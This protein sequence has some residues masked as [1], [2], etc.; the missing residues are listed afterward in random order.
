MN[1]RDSAWTRLKA[2]RWASTLGVLVT[3]AVGIL[4]GTLISFSV[5]GQ[6]KTVNSSDATPITIPPAKVVQ[7]DFSRIAKQIEPAV[8]NI[9]T[10]G[11]IKHPSMRG[12]PSPGEPPDNGGGDEDN[13]F[14][15]FFDRFFGGQGGG[16]SAIP[17]RSL[18][19]GVIV[20]PKGY[21]ITN[22]H[23]VEG[24]DRVRVV[25]TS[26]P[27]GSLGHDAKVIGTD[28][29]TDLA[30]VKINV[31]KPLPVAH[32]GNSD[33]LVVGDWVLAVGSP[34]G[35]NA[36]VTAGIV[37]Y[38][39]RNIVPA[40]QFQSFIQTDAAINPGNSG[41]PMVNM[42]GQVVGI[43]TAIMTGGQGYEGVG[44]ALPSN[45][46]AQVYNA[47]ISPDHKVVRGSIGVEFQAVQNPAVLR[48]YGNGENGVVISNIAS[49][50]P[51]DQA[52]LKVGDSIVSVDG[53][54]VKN[55]DAL[56]ADI[57]ARKP[58]TKA[59]VGYVREGKQGTTT[60]TIGSRSQIWAARLNPEGEEGGVEAQPQAESKL[61]VTVQN[62]TSDMAQRL[63]IPQKGV[64]VTDVKPGSPADDWG[65]HRGD[66][67]L[68]LN[69]QPINNDADFRRLTSNLKSGQ[70]V[71]FMV[72]SG[73]GENAGTA[74]LGGTL[75]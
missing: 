44:F 10:E 65:L 21:I 64:I 9:N 6:D 73:R 20:D 3:L 46:V 2:R 29:E 5:R 19:S 37:S 40:Q 35:L 68:Q 55:G 67:L 11:T 33:G 34:F 66:V 52:G 18:G 47:L 14:Q 27:E 72:R 69:R 22:R 74:F 60:I 1:E 57:A 7:N 54:P 24:A 39:G 45:T 36:T 42:D 25:L 63:G 61:G 53:K 23:V 58:G 30:V 62:V 41:G 50:G 26:D 48:Q 59:S 16:Q 17:T 31:D 75:P 51:A 13:P 70:D 28:Q 38:V 56:V 49:G 12:R 4:I 43:N 8:V 15:D 71:V 32:L